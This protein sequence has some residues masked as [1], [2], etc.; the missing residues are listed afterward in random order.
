MVLNSLL[1]FRRTCSDYDQL[2]RAGLDRVVVDDELLLHRASSLFAWSGEVEEVSREYFRLVPL[3]DLAVIIRAR[4]EV[5][6]SR[7][8][9]RAVIPN[10]YLDVDD[11][12][13][14]S[15]I[16]SALRMTEIAA[17]ELERRGAQV[18]VLDGNR[19]LDANADELRAII[20][21]A[22]SARPQKDLY[23]RLVDVSGSFRRREGRHQLRT[24]GVAYCAFSVPGYEVEPH[25]AQRD[26]SKRL[27][28]FGAT[29]EKISGRSLLDLGSNAGAMLLQA[30]N[31]GP[32]RGL[33]IE[34]DVDK[35]DTAND[36]VAFA[37]VENIEFRSGDIDH[38]NESV[39]GV[40]DI[41]FALAIEGHVKDP[42]RL[43][44]LLGA[45][46]RETLYFE[47]NSNC[48]LDLVQDR[49]SRAGFSEF[50]HLGFCD[51]DADP[52]NN[53]RPMLVAH[54]SSS[55][56]SRPSDPHELTLEPGKAH[57]DRPFRRLFRGV[58]KHG[59]A[60]RDA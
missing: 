3:P 53:R 11:D 10:I 41:V 32:S 14:R 5:I 21:R 35:V 23:S 54:K 50:H 30:S 28:R 26:A 45:V 13:I 7:S 29:R 8:R 27:A 9:Q 44:K 60:S 22:C 38:L 12:T 52:R 40:H 24:Q 49:L 2:V 42:E 58:V 47:G 15:T 48:D 18:H 34:Y 57:A 19:S 25:K 59:Q 1:I 56:E 6:A 39:V 31:Y 4:P 33:G 36:I 51:D 43:Y 55:V 46:T 20:D 37:N 16:E 17:E